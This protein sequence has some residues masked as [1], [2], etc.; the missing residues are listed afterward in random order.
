MREHISQH[1]LGA[2]AGHGPVL[3]DEWVAMAVFGP[4]RGAELG[5]APTEFPAKQL[6]RSEV[7]I[8]RLK[9]IAKE[10]FLSRVVTP[11]EE[12][13]GPLVGISCAITKNIRDIIYV[14]QGLHPIRS[15]RAICVLDLVVQGDYNA[16]AALGYSESMDTLTEGQ[17]ARVRLVV[18]NDLVRSFGPL[19]S[20]D[21]IS[22]AST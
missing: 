3:D 17:K 12:L 19:Q 16:H 7:S 15:G 21:A 10:E 11:G 8:A 14:V 1:Y 9:Y 2:D 20:I 4:L 5:L 6:K 13:K 18:Q 22:F